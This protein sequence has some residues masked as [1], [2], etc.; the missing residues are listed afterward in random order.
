MLF[1]HESKLRAILAQNEVSGNEGEEIEG[2]EEGR[3]WARGCGWGYG[4][5]SG[6]RCVHRLKPVLPN[7]EARL[8]YN[9]WMGMRLGVIAILVF[10]M[11]ALSAQAGQRAAKTVAKAAP[12]TQLNTVSLARANPGRR[13]MNPTQRQ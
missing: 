8:H 5:A 1:M 9:G 2:G 11:A 7:P 12:C 3:G 10:A 6:P 13:V 4:A